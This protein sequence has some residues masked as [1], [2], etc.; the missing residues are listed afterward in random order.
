LVQVTLFPQKSSFFQFFSSHVKKNIFGLNKKIPRSE[1]GWP[2]I[3]CQVLDS[4]LPLVMGP[5]QK[6]L[7]QVRSGQFFEPWVGS[8]QL[9][10]VRVWKISLKNV[11]FFNFFPLGQVKGGLAS[12]LLLIKSLLG[13]GRVRAHL[14]LPPLNL[15]WKPEITFILF[16]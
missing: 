13:P 8:G 5:G 7:T 16:L 4:I 10:M 11:K 14:L 6:L 2:L 12:Y 3:N 9:S 15:F 1:P